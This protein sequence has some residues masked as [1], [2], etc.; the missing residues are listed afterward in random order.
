MKMKQKK[1]QYTARAGR[2]EQRLRLEHRRLLSM[3]EQ[4]DPY[5]SVASLYDKYGQSAFLDPR[6]E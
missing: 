5:A 6:G 3:W 4:Y 1:H 2:R